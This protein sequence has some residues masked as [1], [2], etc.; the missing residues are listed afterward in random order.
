M[1][2]YADLEFTAL[3]RQCSAGCAVTIHQFTA[4]CADTLAVIL[5]PSDAFRQNV[6]QVWPRRL[7]PA[8]CSPCK[9]ACWT[10]T[11]HL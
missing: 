10:M 9:F 7:S 2:W 6:M 1:S 3:S 8:H 11:Q 5:S 4:T